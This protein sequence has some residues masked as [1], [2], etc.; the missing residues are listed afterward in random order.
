MARVI[1]VRIV[2]YLSCVIYV[3]EHGGCIRLLRR[4]ADDAAHV[5]RVYVAAAA[6]VDLPRCFQRAEIVR[7]GYRAV[8]HH[9]GYAADA[10]VTLHVSCVVGVGYV[11]VDVGVILLFFYIVYFCCTLR[12]YF[13]DD[14]ADVRGFCRFGDRLLV[15]NFCGMHRTTVA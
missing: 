6:V 11:C 3:V 14:A 2:A 4:V 10:G 8:V 12:I 13:P 1:C 5:E 9:A 7:T 15:F